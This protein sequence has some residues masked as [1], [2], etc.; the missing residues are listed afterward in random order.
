MLG[1]SNFF[2][3]KRFFFWISNDSVEDCADAKKEKKRSKNKYISVGNKPFFCFLQAAI[4]F[5]K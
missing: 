3:Q 1:D 2:Q 4:I 5:K